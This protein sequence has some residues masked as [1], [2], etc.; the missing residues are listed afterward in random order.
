MIKMK[1][2]L[3]LR[4]IARTLLGELSETVKITINK[5][6]STLQRREYPVKPKILEDRHVRRYSN[7]L[8]E[9]HTIIPA[10]KAGKYYFIQTLTREL[11]IES[12]STINCTYAA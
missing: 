10:D 4:V 2:T 6:I 5:R 8:Q 7:E 3:G 9:K 12:K 1:L 11:E